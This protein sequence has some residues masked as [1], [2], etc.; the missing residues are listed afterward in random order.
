MFREKQPGD[1][2]HIDLTGSQGNAFY[3][4][5]LV[6]SLKHVL[7]PWKSVKE[8]QDEMMSGDYEHLLEVFDGYFGNYVIM[9]R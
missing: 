6:K 2:I 8:V 5:G 3:I 9:E 4:L 1:L 7:P